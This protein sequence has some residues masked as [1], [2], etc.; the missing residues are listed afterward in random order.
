MLSELIGWGAKYPRLRRP[1]TVLFRQAWRAQRAT[2]ARAVLVIENQRDGV[3]MH[4]ANGT[5]ALPVLSLDPWD[6]ITPQVE[7]WASALL[8][9]RC[10]VKL[11]AVEGTP[12][13]QGVI[14]LYRAKTEG[15]PK[16]DMG[17]STD[18]VW[19]DLRAVSS[20]G[21]DENDLRRL[22]LCQAHF[23]NKAPQSKSS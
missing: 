4:A 8:N 7:T 5:L 15:A 22:N 17:K 6:A 20:S 21:L 14:F 13:S 3:L 9:Q 11:V 18:Q 23:A 19:I 1:F 16:K 12:S 2:L 10:R